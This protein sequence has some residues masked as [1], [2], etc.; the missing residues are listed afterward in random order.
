MHNQT[1]GPRRSA[2]TL[3]LV[4]CALSPSTIYAQD[5]NPPTLDEIVVTASRNAEPL[6]T[7]VGDVSV[8]GRAQLQN[9]NG[10][11]LAKILGRSPGIQF[12]DNGGPQTTTGLFIRGA[13]PS[14]SLIMINGVRI[15]SALTGSTLFPAIDPSQIERIE[16]LRGSA[17]SLYGSNAIG[18]VVNIITRHDLASDQPFNFWA[19]AGYGTYETAKTSLGMYGASH[20]WDY[21]LAGSANNSHGFN[22]AR[23][24]MADGSDNFSYQK[25]RDG[26]RSHSWSGALG[27]RWGA[28]HR[29]G[30]QAYNGYNKADI[31]TWSGA[32]NATN[33]YRQQA[34]SLNSTD[35]ITSIWQSVLQWDWAKDAVANREDK[36]STFTASIRQNLSWQNNLDFLPGQRISLLLEH[37][38]ERIQSS[39]EFDKSQRQINTAGLIYKGQFGAVRTQASV[40]NDN[41]TDYGNQAT[42]SLALDYALDANWEVGI[43][44][45]TGFRMPSFADLYQQ[46]PDPFYP[47]AGN[48]NLQ[49]E[50]SRNVEAH[51]RYEDDTKALGLTVYQ[52]RVRNL[53]LYV[54]APFMQTSTM[55]NVSRATLQGLSLDGMYRFGNTRISANLNLLNPRNDTPQ[56]ADPANFVQAEGSQLPLRARQVLNLGVEHTI[57][58]WTLGAEY[59]YTGNRYN[60]AANKVRLGGYSLVNLTAE[61]QFNKSIGMQLRWNNIFA[62][63][64]TIA[65]GYST[66]G[67]NVFVNLSW[68]M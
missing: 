49:P 5:S 65:D 6:A 15:N 34:Y 63:D 12:I 35:Q 52:N 25:D 18:G 22:V 43:A 24:H 67:S 33:V 61:Y 19:N 44:G 62:K 40:R 50:K 47:Y 57:A 53:I 51:I 60:D 30:V 32:S 37:Q 10:E 9:A 45:N 54:P 41:Y 66:P 4:L 2:T 13:A 46:L 58:A 38:N 23:K 31:D 39:S 59:Q 8:I 55:R 36:S 64:Y 26:Y 14:Q 27:Y 16:V 17:S 29:I 20:G 48:P 21:S 7:A 68:R 28:G 1:H 42:A 56:D 3:A 11:S